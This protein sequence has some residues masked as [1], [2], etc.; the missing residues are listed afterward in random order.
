MR[1]VDHDRIT[2]EL[3]I[4]GYQFPEIENDRW[5]S[6]WLMVTGRVEHPRGAWS[7]RE[8]CLTAFEVEDLAGWLDGVASGEADARAGYFTE[9]NLEFRYLKHPE[10]AIEVSLGYESA[11]PWARREAV[12]LRFPIAM[13]DPKAAAR[14][15]RG[16]LQIFPPRGLTGGAA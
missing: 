3:V 2:L 6:N 12:T 4:D 15:L 11:P 1:L 14:A 9:P 16:Y 13:N 8:P 10:P 5:D 7:F